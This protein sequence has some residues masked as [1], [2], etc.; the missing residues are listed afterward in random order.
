MFSAESLHVGQRFVISGQNVH[1]FAALLQ[2]GPH[3][4][5]TASPRYK[6][7]GGEVVAWSLGREGAEI[8][9]VAAF[10]VTRRFTP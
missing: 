10:L 4:V 8:V 6:V 3:L 1:A 2:N 5:Q 9:D 7:A